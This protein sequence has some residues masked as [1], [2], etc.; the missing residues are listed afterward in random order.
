MPHSTGVS[1]VDRDS[2][3]LVPGDVINLSNSQLT[4]VPADLF[5]LSGD[6]ILNESMLTGESVPVSKIPVKEDDLLRWQEHKDE[7]SKSVLYGGTKVIRIRGLTA[8]NGSVR[9]ALALVLR[10]GTFLP[11]AFES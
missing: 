9:P 7:S 4:L 2:S 6:A 1:G 5:L 11:W 3:D 10:T 8:P